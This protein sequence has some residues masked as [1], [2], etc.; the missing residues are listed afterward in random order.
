MTYL[1]YSDSLEVIAPDESETFAG[2]AETFTK[3]GETVAEREG[4]A[5]RVS[6]AKPTGLLT[7]T[8]TIAAG[9]PPELAQ[10]IAATPARYEA[11]IRFAQGPGEMLDDK[12][13]THRGMAVKL[14]DVPGERIA[15]AGG[16]QG[17]DFVLEAHGKAFINADAKRFLA[18]LR[19]GVSHAPSL[20]EGVKS[21][22]SKTARAAEAG[23]EAV[24]LEVK[25]LDFF[26]HAP[27][28]PLAEAYFSQV[29]MRWGGYVA[30][31]GFYPTEE[32]CAS[33]G[34][35]EVDN[36]DDP[37][38]FRHAMID[39]FARSGATFEFRVQLA[40]DPD[41]TPIEDATVE[42]PEHASP[43]QTVGR[44]EIP[45]QTAWSE[46]RDDFFTPLSFRPAH[47]LAAHRPLG[48]VMRA[49]LFVYERLAAFRRTRNGEQAAEPRSIAEVPA[50]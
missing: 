43:Y 17:Q 33:L 25:T 23:L 19:A 41:T 39:H 20:P 6:H 1:P 32:T 28:H 40:V 31:V 5:L 45:A 49:R 9:L 15:E 44:L 46:A 7:G 18:N 16:S 50:G 42:W 37:L 48:Q 22:I 38:A 30:K 35:L 29:P 14:L 3:M 8:L 4:R 26:G 27:L 12:V 10:G 21:V 24:G 36:S 2:I 11:L 47:S 34:E 13:S